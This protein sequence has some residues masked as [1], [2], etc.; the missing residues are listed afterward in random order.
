MSMS[1]F[2]TVSKSNPLGFPQEWYEAN[3]PEHFWFEWRRRILMRLLRQLSLP[4]GRELH[5][6]DIGC[7]T[8]ITKDSIE[9]DTAWIVDGADLNEMALNMCQPGRGRV[10]FYNIED[11]HAEFLNRYDM[12]VIFDVIEHLEHPSSFLDAALKHLKV[13]GICIV[14]VPALP[15]LFGAYDKAVGHHRR[16]TPF[17]LE[18]EF[19]G[20]QIEVLKNIYWGFLMTPVVWLRKLFVQDVNKVV[21]R[22]FV[23]PSR[24]ANMMLSAAM[25]FETTCVGSVPLGSSIMMAVQKIAS[26]G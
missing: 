18:M 25:N 9:R 8:G 6:L 20:K 13:G 4:T 2:E 5:C 23:P 16:Y 10:L 1:R 21:R 11:C 26:K 15:K 19:K 22:G 24:L 3:S 12:I 17:L 7:G 14:N